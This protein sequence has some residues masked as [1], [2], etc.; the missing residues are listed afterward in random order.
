MTSALLEGEGAGPKHIPL[1]NKLRAQVFEWQFVVHVGFLFVF[2]FCII[3]ACSERTVVC[4]V[5]FFL[6]N[7]LITCVILS[8]F[9]KE[10]SEL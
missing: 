6:T 1:T 3:S 9:F 8:S 2:F 5:L 4:C 7:I 10:V